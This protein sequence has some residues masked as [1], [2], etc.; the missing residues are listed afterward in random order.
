MGL[1]NVDGAFQNATK[2]STW[3]DIKES[4]ASDNLVEL[5]LHDVYGM[6]ILLSIGLNGSV[7][8]LLVEKA[9]K[10]KFKHHDQQPLANGM[11][12]EKVIGDI[13]PCPAEEPRELIAVEEIELK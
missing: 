2:C 10:K 1:I 5:L 3:Q 7:L 9:V 11:K 13:L 4:H 12:G 6:L 8:G